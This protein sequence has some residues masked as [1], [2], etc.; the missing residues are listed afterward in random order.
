[1]CQMLLYLNRDGKKRYA[2]VIM[3]IDLHTMVSFGVVYQALSFRKSE[4]WYVEVTVGNE[5]R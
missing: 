2:V 4:W 1:M 5:R 3:G